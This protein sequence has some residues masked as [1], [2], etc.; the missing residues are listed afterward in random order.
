MKVHRVR[1][2]G[3]SGLGLVSLGLPVVIFVL[4]SLHA[5]DFLSP[6]NIANVNSQIAALM[7]VALGQLIVV[8][9]GGIDISVG[10]VVSLT[11]VLDRI[12][13]SVIR[14]WRRPSR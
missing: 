1:R 13:R 11:S 8:L 12:A 5:P 7:I 4:L 10:S 2:L 14:A 6:Q 3:R 9:I